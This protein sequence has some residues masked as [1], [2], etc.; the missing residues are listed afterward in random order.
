MIVNTLTLDS[1]NFPPVLK[2]IATPPNILYI[3]GGSLEDLLS[4]PCVTIVGSRKVSAYGEAVTQQ[5]AGELAREGV[6]IVSGLA[7]GVDSVAHRAALDAGGLTIAVLPTSLD[8]IYPAHHKGLAEQIIKQGGALI[9][10]YPKGTT[11]Y[12]T[13]F[14]ARNRIVSGISQVTVITE[15]AIKS[16]SIHTAHFALEQGK[17][18]MAV[19]GNITSPNSKGTNHLIKTGAHPVTSAKDVLQ[20]L[21]IQPKKARRSR[22]IGD[23]PEQ[24]V[25]LQLLAKG[26]NTSPALLAKSG[27]DIQVFDQ[28][29]TMLE[30]TGKVRNLGN[31]YWSLP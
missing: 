15:A 5:L 1:P 22:P 12:K 31:G 9:T 19:P 21:G 4:R 27:L 20:L 13:N 14:V 11:A 8:S 24:E 10:E 23:T 16:G 17:D 7:Y 30:I 2:H 26:Q 29:I 28:H 25:I 3:A 6:V 18:V